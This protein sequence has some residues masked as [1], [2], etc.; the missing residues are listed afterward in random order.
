MAT[1][2][3]TPGGALFKVVKWILDDVVEVER[4]LSPR[5]YQV[6]QYAMFTGTA[7]TDFALIDLTVAAM[8]GSKLT[9]SQQ[10]TALQI[11]K[12][13]RVKIPLS[14]GTVPAKPHP[15]YGIRRI[16]GGPPMSLFGPLAF[17]GPL[18]IQ[19]ARTLG[20]FDYVNRSSTQV[21]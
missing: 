2:P 9:A 15:G 3:V 4:Y 20:L 1:I 8:S 11:G 13:W 5:E 6:L 7:V 21:H 19:S 16:G 14:K 10:A 18:L 17:G 12:G